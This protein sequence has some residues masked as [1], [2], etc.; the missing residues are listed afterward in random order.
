M[1]VWRFSWQQFCL[2]SISQTRSKLLYG[3]LWN[4]S[5][6]NIQ[7]C[8]ALKVSN[9]WFS[10]F[11]TTKIEAPQWSLQAVG[12]R[13]GGCAAGTGRFLRQ[14]SMDEFPIW[15]NAKNIYR[16]YNS[17]IIHHYIL[18]IYSWESSLYMFIYF[19]WSK[20][21]SKVSH[22]SG[23]CFGKLNG[24]IHQ[25]YIAA[26]GDDGTLWW[27]GMDFA[28]EKGREKP[29]KWWFNQQKSWFSMMQPTKVQI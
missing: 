13:S 20:H 4:M 12:Q 11:Q 18:Y 14:P 5:Q 2:G 9:P 15:S 27:L 17:I 29:Q 16:I 25:A 1:H 7:N 8:M 28:K 19:I 6:I 22:T 10:Q 21:V 26:G 24:M 3:V 23:W